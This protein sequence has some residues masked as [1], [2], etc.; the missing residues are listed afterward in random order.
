MEGDVPSV[1]LPTLKV[2]QL[3][4]IHLDNGRDISGKV[5]TVL[6]EI[7][8]KTQLGKVRISID[9]DPTIRAGMF[10]TGTINAS[11]SC[12]VSIPLSSVQY[13]TE[14][15]TVQLVHDDTVETHR[16]RLGFY[17]DTAVEVLDGVKQGDLV[18]ANAGT[19]LHDGDQVKPIVADN[20]SQVGS[21]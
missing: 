14:G 11:H 20:S 15:T 2:G 6:P 12:G 1:H 10:A 18:I 7:D 9:S 21:Q 19:A 17:S 3:A 5:R 16:V 13:Q 8:R 4:R